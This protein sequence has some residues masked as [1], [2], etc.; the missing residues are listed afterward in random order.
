M[1]GSGSLILLVED[2]DEIG[3]L[4]AEHLRATLGV[5]V[6]RAAS[7]AEALAYD[8][9]G[10]PD[11]LLAD[12]L[13]PDGDGLEL[14]RTIR[15]TRD[16]PILLMTGA[17]TLGRAVEAMRLGV[18]YLFTKPFDLDRLTQVVKQLLAKYHAQGRRRQRQER[19]QRLTRQV[20]RE[21]KQLQQRVDLVCRDLVDSYRH[22]TERFVQHREHTSAL[23]D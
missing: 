2:D 8:A 17:P 19:L 9:D 13:L 15:A 21:R 18:A 4:V 3:R 5:D 16:Y 23:D 6:Q 20:I 14:I 7:K 22:L 1:T 10:P 11:L 12:L